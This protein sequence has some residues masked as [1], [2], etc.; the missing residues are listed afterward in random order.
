MT[1][2]QKPNKSVLFIRDLPRT[3]KNKF[4]AWCANRGVT[5][6]DKIKELMRDTVKG[7]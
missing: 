3:L 5:M 4:K 6:H 2:I 7:G 1:T